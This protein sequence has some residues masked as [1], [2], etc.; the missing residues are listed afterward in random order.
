MKNPPDKSKEK[1]ES[2]FD[3]IAPAYDRLNHL[4]TLNIDKRWRKQIIRYISVN[5]IKS[6]NILDLASGTGD[7]TKELITLNPGNIYAADISSKMLDIQR[8]KIKYE[9]LKLIQTEAQTLPFEDEYFDIVTIGFGVRN[10]FNLRE[11]LK[12][13]KRVLRPE[14][15]LII[16]EMFK[17][18]GLKTSLFN[19]YFGKIMP[20]AGNKISNSSAYSYLFNSVNTFLSIKEFTELCEICGFKSESIKNNF[21]G[22]VNTLY[23]IKKNI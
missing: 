12:E 11:S 4:F 18:E 5:K 19:L 23:L 1:I 16:L 22:I 7:L 15:K 2:M 9:N 13:I 6:D 8:N 21:L 10:F 20:Y 3:E 17:A 14:G